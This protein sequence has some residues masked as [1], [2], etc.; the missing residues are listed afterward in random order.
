MIMGCIDILLVT[1]GFSSSNIDVITLDRYSQLNYRLPTVTDIFISELV[2]FQLTDYVP[3]I[4]VTIISVFVFIRLKNV[5]VKIREVFFRPFLSVF[6][7]TRGE[8]SWG[9]N[10]KHFVFLFTLL[11][12]Y[13]VHLVT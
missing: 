10:T 13:L 6:T 3:T 12:S 1:S 4:F 9:G 2:R 11:R 8:Y 5:K 7:H